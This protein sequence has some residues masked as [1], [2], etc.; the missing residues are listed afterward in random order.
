MLCAGIARANEPELAY[1]RSHLDMAVLCVSDP[2]SGCTAHGLV[3]AKQVLDDPKTEL[4]SYRTDSRQTLVQFVLAGIGTGGD[5]G[6]RYK[7]AAQLL[8]RGVDINEHGSLGL[9]ALED[10]VLAGNV[11]QLNWLLG[12]GADVHAMAGPGKFAGK[13]A[14]AFAYEMKRAKHP[15][16]NIDRLIDTLSKRR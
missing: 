4:K 15:P 14:L 11:E 3:L 13:D 8:T 2:S 7:M 5:D 1:F 10:A 16:S 12:K 9:T 6:A